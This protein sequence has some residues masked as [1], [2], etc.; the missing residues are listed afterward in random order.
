MSAREMFNIGD[1]VKCIKFNKEALEDGIEC[2]N[3]VWKSFKDELLSIVCYD[4][5]HNDFVIIAYKKWYDTIPNYASWGVHISNLE[6][7][8]RNKE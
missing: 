2:I 7:V 6:K 8:G 3:E 5:D 1:T 4:K